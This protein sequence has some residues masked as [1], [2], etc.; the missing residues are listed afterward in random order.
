MAAGDTVPPVIG[1]SIAV[2]RIK[3]G[4]LPTVLGGF[5]AQNIILHRRDDAD[6]PASCV[7]DITSLRPFRRRASL[8]GTD[9]DTFQNGRPEF[10][11]PG[12]RPASVRSLGHVHREPTCRI[13]PG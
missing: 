9:A 8:D 5:R 3:R 7:F 12:F 11:G 4:H 1:I 10:V 13:V 2:L 6:H